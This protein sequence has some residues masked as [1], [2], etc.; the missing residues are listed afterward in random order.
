VGRRSA[1][2]IE[3]WRNLTLE[4]RP[5]VRAL[6]PRGDNKGRTYTVADPI[7]GRYEV[8]R[9]FAS[10]GC[11][12][13]L[14]G[15]DRETETEVLIKTTL[16]YDVSYHARHRD[17]AGFTRQLDHTRK[18]L[19]T[20]RR[21]LVLLRNQGCNAVPN[22]NDYVYD[23]NPLLEGPHDT[24]DGRKWKYDDESRLASEPYLVME[25]IEGKTLEAII[26]DDLPGGMEERRALAVLHQ[27]C[28]VLRVLHR[29]AQM[30]RGAVW[31][32]VYQDLKP[33][34]IMLGK[35]DYATLI[36]L[37]GCQLQVDGLIKLRGAFTPGY[38]PP[39]CGQEGVP[40]RPAADS[41]TVGSTLFHLLTGK[42]PAEFLPTN[43]AGTGAQAVA[44]D[45]WDWELLKQKASLPTCALVRRCLAERPAERP[46]GAA[47][48]YE[49]IGRLLNRP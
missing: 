3:N 9:F 39:E 23:R 14:A 27:V 33:A 21:L 32:I 48:L 25:A 45:R 44:H 29:P 41:Y 40:L 18:Q 42:A 38:C 46:A 4:G 43:L 49:E 34:N 24:E 26:E 36:D 30:A 20:E 15:R 10:G 28:N 5:F 47:E 7:A 11:G 17:R 22:P 31:N 19:E 12:L 6:V 37:G 2:E 8:K 35:H 1:W 16:W 13:L